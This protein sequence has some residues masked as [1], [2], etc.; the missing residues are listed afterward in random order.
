MPFTDH[1]LTPVTD[2]E[3]VFLGYRPVRK[4]EI[5]IPFNLYQSLIESIRLVDSLEGDLL[6]YRKLKG[7]QDLFNDAFIRFFSIA[8]LRNMDKMDASLLDQY[9]RY[10]GFSNDKNVYEGLSSRDKRRLLKSAIQFW[11]RKGLELAYSTVIEGMS[12]YEYTIRDW[13]FNRAVVDN[14][15]MSEH[16]TEHDSLFLD[17]FY[18]DTRPAYKTMIDVV[19]EDLNKDLFIDLLRLS[20][21]ASERL[22]IQYCYLLDK[23]EQFGCTNWDC[24]NNVLNN[25]RVELSDGG[26]MITNRNGRTK[27]NNYTIRSRVS[28]DTNTSSCIVSFYSDKLDS[29]TKNELQVEYGVNSATFRAYSNGGIIDTH[30]ESYDPLVIGR[31]YTMTIDVYDGSGSSL[32]VSVY[33]DNH[34]I[35]TLNIPKYRNRGYV[36]LSSVNGVKVDYVDVHDIYNFGYVGVPLIIRPKYSEVDGGDTIDFSAFTNGGEPPY[37]FQLT[38]DNSNASLTPDGLYTSGVVLDVFDTVEVTDSVDQK[39]SATIRVR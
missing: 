35:M 15:Y 24:F 17:S 36:A 8:D 7:A 23:F 13:F 25:N 9:I 26:Y 11:K 1:W 16:L 12:G 14:I 38:V 31:L 2:E 29:D 32:N 34:K 20:R 33:L 27:W 28:L 19:D 18:S 30:T 3:I 39:A 37:T 22:F 5:V 4:D 10:L 6:H 21:P